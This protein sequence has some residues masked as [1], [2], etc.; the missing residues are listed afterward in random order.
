M[1][2]SAGLLLLHLRR[3]LRVQLAGEGLPRYLPEATRDTHA[4]TGHHVPGSAMCHVPLEGPSTCTRATW[5]LSHLHTRDVAS[6]SPAHTLTWPLPHLHIHGPCFTVHVT[7]PLSLVQPAPPQRHR[8]MGRAAWILG[9]AFSP[10]PRAPGPA[11][12]RGPNSHTASHHFPAWGLGLPLHEE[13]DR[14]SQPTSLSPP[15]HPGSPTLATPGHRPAPEPRAW[16]PV[17][18]WPCRWPPCK[19]ATMSPG[20]SRRAGWECAPGP[21]GAPRWASHPLRCDGGKDSGSPAVSGASLWLQTWTSAWR[22]AVSRPASTPPGATPA[23][24]TGAGA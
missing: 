15:D 16:H 4:H 9:A 2:E 13:G 14:W 6:A 23:T 1:P 8:G 12:S 20:R 18:T 24:V 11:M 17:P 21:P 10:A 7:W 19:H 3:G 22:N 5:R